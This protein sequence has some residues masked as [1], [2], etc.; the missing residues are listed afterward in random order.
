MRACKHHWRYRVNPFV[1]DSPINNTKLLLKR[2]LWIKCNPQQ[3]RTLQ[4]CPE[5][6][7]N[8]FMLRIKVQNTSWKMRIGSIAGKRNCSSGSRK[9]PCHFELSF[10]LSH[11][12]INCTVTFFKLAMPDKDMHISEGNIIARNEQQSIKFAMPSWFTPS[13]N[14]VRYE[15]QQLT[16]VDFVLRREFDSNGVRWLRR[17]D[18]RAPFSPKPR[19]WVKKERGDLTSSE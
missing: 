5:L 15:C 2:R 1:P 7:E 8:I 3:I 12:R 17:S 6:K 10:F 9:P 16:R 18:L 14:R 13:V 4:H 11:G 19:V